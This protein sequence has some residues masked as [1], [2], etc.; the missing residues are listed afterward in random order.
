ML[1]LAQKYLASLDNNYIWYEK[2]VTNLI[3]Q[4]NQP[5]DH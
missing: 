2:L 3:I 4:P 1:Q 5:K